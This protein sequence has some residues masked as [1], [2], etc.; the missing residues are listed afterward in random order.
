LPNTRELAAQET[1][2]KRVHRYFALWKKGRGASSI[3]EWPSPWGDVFPGWH[4]GSAP[5]M[6]TQNILGRISFDS[7][8]WRYGPLNFHNHDIE[9]AQLKP[10]NGQ[11][12]R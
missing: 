6:S 12:R 4:F 1:K 7:S 2:K 3:S 5:P 8:W 11:W 10:S 9:I